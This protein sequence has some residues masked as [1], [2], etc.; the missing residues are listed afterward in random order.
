MTEY[1]ALYAGKQVCCTC[2]YYCQHYRRDRKKYTPVH[3]G[4]CT[5][6]RVKTCKPDK[7]CERWRAKKE[8]QSP[9]R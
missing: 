6:I 8:A 3:C 4:H 7:S 5:V 1:E 2:A 9:G